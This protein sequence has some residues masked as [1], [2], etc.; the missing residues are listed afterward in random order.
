MPKVKSRQFETFEDGLL[1]ICAADERKLTQNKMEHIRFGNR[2]AG[3]QRYWQAKTAGNKVDRLLSVPLSVLTII[4]VETQDVVIVETDKTE[5][6]A[7]QYH[8]IQ[9]QPK[10]DAQPPALYLS[11]EKV[12]HPYNDGRAEDGN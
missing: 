6:S 8:I 12:V 2:T 3:V 1:T 5:N 7:N 9:V 10:F 11:L 4:T